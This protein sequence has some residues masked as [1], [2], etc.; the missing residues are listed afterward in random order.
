MKRIEKSSIVHTGSKR[1]QLNTGWRALII[2]GILAVTYFTAYVPPE[3]E[4]GSSIA[5]SERN[6]MSDRTLQHPLQTDRKVHISGSFGEY[7]HF[8]RYHH[9]LD[10]KTFNRVGFPVIAPLDGSISRIHVADYGY[11][12]GLWL[13]TPDGVQMTFGH[14]LDYNCDRPDLEYFR[15]AIEIMD[16]DRRTFV[17][18]PPWFRFEK[19]DCIARSGES[20]VGAPHLHFEIEKDGLYIDPLSVSGL[21]IPDS[22]APELNH[23]YLETAAGTQV[24]A[25]EQLS[26]TTTVSGQQR[27]QYKLA[28]G[29]QPRVSEADVLRV[30]VGGYDTMAARNRNGVRRVELKQGEHTLYAHNLDRI[31]IREFTHAA[32]IYHTV[33]TIIGQEYVYL[34]YA[35]TRSNVSPGYAVRNLER[36]TNG[37]PLSILVSD[38]S[39]NVSTVDFELSVGEATTAEEAAA[40]DTGREQP[41]L[42]PDVG[43]QSVSDQSRV[44]LQAAGNNAEMRITFQP[45][46]VQV[47]GRVRL[48]DL[49]D[50]PEGTAEHVL[51]AD[52]R[53]AEGQDV[54]L[55]RAG[56]VF[57]L[58]GQDLAYLRGAEGEAIFPDVNEGKV[59]L[60]Y[61]NFTVGQWRLVAVPRRR[62]NGKLYY[63][64]PVRFD[65]PMA[66]LEDISPPVLGNPF[67]WEAATVLNEGGDSFVYE[68]SVSDRGGGFNLQNSTVLLDGRKFPFDWINDR[69]V[70][71][72][73]IPRTIIPEQGC[74]LSLQ[75]GDHNGNLSDWAFYFIEQPD[76][77]VE[78][79]ESPAVQKNNSQ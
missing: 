36:N 56:P 50:L 78:E 14:L 25:L 3:A 1:R 75:V 8:S 67:I 66:Q 74:V 44:R 45:Y 72:V 48:F 41:R 6:F 69:S 9:G 46:S 21:S 42:R 12:N 11:G 34:L 64:F 71:R 10:Y 63:Y 73:S 40:S 28:D 15:Q 20:G 77:I 17:N 54:I 30:F 70:I 32:Q 37:I 24:F 68:I 60:Y 27:I 47:P 62:A 57:Y 19:G 76:A 61:F 16:P 26:S 79:S 38:A 2:P 59:G 22:T 39:G 53:A 43:F 4:P 55:R 31:H 58:E 65:G 23:V 33:R 52:G 51:P 7:R 29:K 13:R 18:I 5:S 49:P 35:S